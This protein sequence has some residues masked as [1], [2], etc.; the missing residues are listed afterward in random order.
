MEYIIK[1]IIEIILTIMT[2]ILLNL[3]KKLK[4]LITVIETNRTSII[5]VIKNI[6]IEKFYLYKNE[7]TISLAEK[8]TLNNLYLEYKKLGGNSII[9]DLREEIDKLPI[10]KDC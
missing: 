2:T 10:K 3:Y 5:S 9:D 1:Y 4:K 8:E 6:Y 7:G